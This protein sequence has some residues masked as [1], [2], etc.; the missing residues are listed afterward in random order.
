MFKH[1]IPL[2]NLLDNKLLSNKALPDYTLSQYNKE[3]LLQATARDVL[4]IDNLTSNLYDV[5]KLVAM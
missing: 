4:L 2:T 3:Y 1:R 5:P